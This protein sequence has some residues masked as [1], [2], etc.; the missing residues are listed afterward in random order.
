M[1]SGELQHSANAGKCFPLS[2]TTTL[3]NQR[4]VGVSRMKAFKL[5]NTKKRSQENF[6]ENFT[7]P[8]HQ[9]ISSIQGRFGA[10]FRISP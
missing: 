10:F 4:E 7:L 6:F 1:A 5:R 2:H 3:R 8:Q 9:K